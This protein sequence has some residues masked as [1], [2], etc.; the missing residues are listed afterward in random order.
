MSKPFQYGFNLANGASGFRTVTNSAMFSAFEI[1]FGVD[2]CLRDRSGVAFTADGAVGDYLRAAGVDVVHYVCPFYSHDV[3]FIGLPARRGPGRDPYFP[4]LEVAEAADKYGWWL[5]CA[6]GERP[7]GF[8]HSG[9]PLY[10]LDVGNRDFRDWYVSLVTRNR[11]KRRTLRFDCGWDGSQY[12]IY[13]KCAI[14]LVSANWR[15]DKS[16]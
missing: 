12:P 8:K 3:K 7:T 2:D 4:R 9:E 1:Q 11:G 5:T 14:P 10:A 6:D 13:L 15:R 16:G